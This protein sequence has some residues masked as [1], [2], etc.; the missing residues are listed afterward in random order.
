MT[1]ELAT[2][3]GQE[4]TRLI[5]YSNRELVSVLGDHVSISEIFGFITGAASVWLCVKLRT[6][7]WPIGILNDLFFLILFWSAGLYA[8]SGLQ[9]LYVVLGAWGWWEWV[10]GGKD[11]APLPVSSTSRREWIA[12]AGATLAG[13]LLLMWLLRS[14]TSSTVVFWDSLTAMVSIAATWGQCLKKIESWYLWIA[15]DVIYV[16]LYASQHLGLTA[17]LYV[18]FMVM[19]LVGL[20]DWKRE[21]ALQGQRELVIDVA[22]R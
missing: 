2:T 13:T 4:V 14:T 19:C 9:I 6:S 16:P 3:I 1:L 12:L 8:N 22:I 21:L 5:D 10:H 17:V 18:G 20:R 11:R 15:V 7:N